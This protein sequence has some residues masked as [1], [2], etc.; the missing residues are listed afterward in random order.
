M[1]R[2]PDPVVIVGAG[3]SGLA[4]ARAVHEAGLTPLVLEA[5]DR[6]AGSWPAYYNSLTLF[7]PARYSAMPGL[8]FPGDPDHYPH[9]DE[10][11]GYLHSYAAGLDVEIRTGTRVQAVERDGR[12]F[13][14]RTADGQEVRAGGVVAA[15][16]SF[17]RPVRPTW[18]G[19][20]S[21]TGQ[22]RHVADY[23]DPKDLAGLRVVVVGAGNSAVQVAY[24]LGEVAQVSIASRRP[25]AFL[26]QRREGHDVHH[27][28]TSSGFDDLPLEWLIHSVQQT[29]AMDTGDYRA[30]IESGRLQRREMLTGFDGDAV[31]WPG[32]ERERVDV[33]LL[34]TGY[35]PS[36]SYLRPLGALTPDGLPLHQGGISTVL[37]GL[38]YLGL[39]FQR[40]FASNTLRGVS[41]DAAY[42]VGPLAAHVGDAPSH[43]GL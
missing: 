18:P 14:V 28:L 22:V 1:T 33:V 4:A 23:R 26:P 25:L 35:L 5:G 2:S 41:R 42:V 6:P 40:S 37:P 34:A 38:V 17:S 12:A 32:G 9:R 30:A 29:L 16:G 19:Q 43:L 36:L 3:Q 13:V 39:E 8:D 24:E 7:S 10:V 15:S 27:W 20:E 11:A 31:V 21:F